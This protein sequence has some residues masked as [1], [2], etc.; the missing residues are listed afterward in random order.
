M[1]KE[2][3]GKKNPRTIEKKGLKNKGYGSNSCGGASKN[4]GNVNRNG[5]GSRKEAIITA[6]RLIATS[7]DQQTLFDHV[8][9]A[10][11]SKKQL[12]P[13]PSSLRPRAGGGGGGGN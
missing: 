13:Y 10:A 1:I 3:L 7:L 6:I 2:D 8:E 11:R 4:T 12:S 5:R 9:F